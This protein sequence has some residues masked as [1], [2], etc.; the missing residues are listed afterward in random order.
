MT[1][2]R[3]AEARRLE[4]AATIERL[5]KQLECESA[6]N[7]RLEAHECDYIASIER[8]EQERDKLR[9]ALEKVQW[10]RDSSCPL[11]EGSPR[12]G[13]APDC[14]VGKALAGDSA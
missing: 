10:K 11:C 1:P 13:H 7:G 8:L 3:R 6:L 14:I 12:Y 2:E 9:V 5:E 4:A